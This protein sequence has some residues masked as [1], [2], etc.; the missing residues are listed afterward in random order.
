M[1]S[2]S[3]F[4]K[5]L[6]K[7]KEKSGIGTDSLRLISIILI[8]AE[9]TITVLVGLFLRSLYNDT[10]IGSIVWFGGG[11]VT[12]ST[13]VLFFKIEVTLRSEFEKVR[14]VLQILDTYMQIRD[15]DLIGFKEAE[16]E[17][18]ATRFDEYLNGEAKVEDGE[19]YRWLGEKLAQKLQSVKA[20]SVRPEEV[21][22]EDDREH[23]WLAAN[24]D[25]AKNGTHIERIFVSTKRSLLCARHREVILTHLRTRNMVAHILWKD[26]LNDTVLHDLVG[27]GLSI[28]DDNTVF[29]DQSYFYREVAYRSEAGMKRIIPRATIYRPPHAKVTALAN[30]YTTLHSY[31]LQ[32]A[33]N[34][35]WLGY[36]H[37]LREIDAFML[38][39]LGTYESA[40]EKTDFTEEQAEDLREWTELRKEVE[41]L[42]KKYAD[43]SLE[44][45]GPLS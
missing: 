15:P 37:K 36:I 43:K 16:L 19:Y 12:I 39:G 25:A 14:S 21:Y 31:L 1:S 7:R 34:S 22:S 45:P 40:I 26:I 2:R 42:E 9:A 33:C 41:E 10:R 28:Y 13:V 24:L 8:L 5:V 38:E 32:S 17:R 20:V 11:M 35:P 23:N 30:M 27:G 18:L 4:F 44:D 3:I 6:P 29:W